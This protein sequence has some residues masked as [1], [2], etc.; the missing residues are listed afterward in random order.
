[1]AQH[2]VVVPHDPNWRKTF[3]AEARAVR[4]ALGENCLAVYHIGSTA[5][6]GLWAKPIL[7]LLPVVRDLEAVDNRR[8]A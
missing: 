4:A 7:D 2:V 5:V 3:T 8:D 1:M 6:E